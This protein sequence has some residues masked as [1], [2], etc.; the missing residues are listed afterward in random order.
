MLFQSDPPG[1][2]RDILSGFL[3][4]EVLRVHKSG[5]F[6]GEVHLATQT[7]PGHHDLGSLVVPGVRS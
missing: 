1:C 4:G 3:G 2:C 6:E 7:D 5:Y